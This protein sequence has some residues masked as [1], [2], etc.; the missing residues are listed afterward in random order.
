MSLFKD[1]EGIP[2]RISEGPKQLLSGDAL[3]LLSKQ[4][5]VIVD[6]MRSG[7][8]DL[9]TLGFPQFDEIFSGK[10]LV[11]KAGDL[12]PQIASGSLRSGN[13]PDTIF[14]SLG[15]TFG[16][17][18]GGLDSIIGGAGRSSGDFS[19]LF[20]SAKQLL[21]GGTDNLV[22]GLF[23]GGSDSILAIAK[24]GEGGL[25]SLFGQAGSGGLGDVFSGLKGLLG[26]SGGLNGILG[27][28]DGIL[29]GAGG[30][31]GMLSKV[32]PAVASLLPL[33][34]Q[35]APMAAAVL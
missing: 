17:G 27:G 19:N 3:D 28:L 8:S 6:A 22:M 13:S 21:G 20:D 35:V 14:E 18:G 26:S 34:L 33:L 16:Q 24:P 30:L 23:K 32:L 5:N 7:P 31:G 25:T 2:S 11:G 9:K 4:S 10:E 1:L 15:K 12:I 29:G